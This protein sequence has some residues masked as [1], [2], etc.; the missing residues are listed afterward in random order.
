METLMSLEASALLSTERHSCWA[1]CT[2]RCFPSWEESSFTVGLQDTTDTHTHTHTDQLQMKSWEEEAD[3]SG[4][5][6][7]RPSLE[8]RGGAQQNSQ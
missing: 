5:D 1:A 8:G 2:M 6:P 7:A 3:R 4:V